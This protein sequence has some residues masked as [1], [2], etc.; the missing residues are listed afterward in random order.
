MRPREAI[1]S[2]HCA[3]SRATWTSAC[4]SAHTP[5]WAVLASA[6]QAAPF[7]AR[8]PADP[9]CRGLLA[10]VA[11]PADEEPRAGA[12]RALLEQ[13]AGELRG[14]PSVVTGG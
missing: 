5:A 10:L 13:G 7:A 4:P 1:E 14:V 8:R 2:F 9:L 11:G 12:A 3:A 6:R